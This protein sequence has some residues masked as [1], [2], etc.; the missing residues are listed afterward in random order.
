MY[1]TAG[2]KGQP[3]MGLQYAVYNTMEK[4][5]ALREG[6]ARIDK[7]Q[8]ELEYKKIEQNNNMTF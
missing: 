3:G 5:W 1:V 6:L 7:K 4:T 8:S 2:S